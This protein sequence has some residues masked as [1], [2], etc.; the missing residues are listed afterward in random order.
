[1]AWS[2]GNNI[3]RKPSSC[4]A[5]LAVLEVMQQEQL[6][7]HAKAIG[8]YLLTE[9]KKLDKIQEV[10]GKGLMIGIDLAP[11]LKEVRKDLL[12]EDHIFTGNASPNVIRL[13]P[14]LT[15]S[16]VEADL[17]LDKFTKRLQQY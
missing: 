11:E 8:D 5:A 14:A 16:E 4:A 13:L 2:I 12:M 9:L 7:V 17:F 10:R 6:V 15:I 3:W 1:M